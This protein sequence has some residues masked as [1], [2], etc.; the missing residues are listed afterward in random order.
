V[1]IVWF[2]SPLMQSLLDNPALMQSMLQGNPAIQSMM[3]SNPEVA[4]MLND[5]ALLRQSMEMAR[6]PRLMN[7]M[8]RNSDRALSNI[9]AMPGGFNALQ[10]M[11]TNVQEPMNN[12]VLNA[13]QTN[14]DLNQAA[15]TNTNTAPSAPLP[16]PWGAYSCLV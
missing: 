8:M 3:Q 12:A 9:E 4:Q 2:S 14:S 16:N 1:L 15:P 5:P 6:N 10:Q 13:N 11:Y 7:E